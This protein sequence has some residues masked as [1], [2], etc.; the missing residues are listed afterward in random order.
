MWK[1]AIKLPAVERKNSS[2]LC[3]VLQIFKIQAAEKKKDYTS[4]AQ[5]EENENIG[6]VRM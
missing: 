5:G 2:R 1:I 6:K 4:S 3:H